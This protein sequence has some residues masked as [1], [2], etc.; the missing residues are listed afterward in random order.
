MIWLLAALLLAGCAAPATK[1]PYLWCEPLTVQG[2]PGL[3]CVPVDPPKGP[4][5]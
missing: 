5:V 1:H 2:T 3:L 4:T